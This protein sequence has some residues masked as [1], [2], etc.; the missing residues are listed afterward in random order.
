MLAPSKHTPRGSS[1]TANDVVMLASYHLS[2]A[3]LSGFDA[4]GDAGG[5]GAVAFWASNG[6][7]GASE[8]KRRSRAAGLMRFMN[9]GT[10]R[11]KCGMASF[12]IMCRIGRRVKRKR[13]ARLSM[14][15]NP[16]KNGT[17]L[18]FLAHCAAYALIPH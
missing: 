15:R 6:V 7:V 14:L 18:Q 1:P 2:K 8:S 9:Y 12:A 16:N 4:A 3:I 10:S 11:G 17:R 5:V 13:P